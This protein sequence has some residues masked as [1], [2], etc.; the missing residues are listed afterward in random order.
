[1]DQVF[2]F[3][4][5]LCYAMLSRFSCVWLC[6]TIYMDCNLPGFSVHGILQVRILGRVAVPS[7]RRSSDSGIKPASLTSPALASRFFTTST[8]L[9]KGLK[10][11][12]K[13]EVAHSCPTLC[14]PTDCSLPGS[15]VHGILQARILEWVAIPFSRGSSQARDWIQVSHIAGGFFTSWATRKAQEFWSG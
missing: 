14:D 15:S 8:T 6:A 12:S 10:V 11:K 13:S 4:K 7:S 9:A 1:M 5:S 2:S 3:A